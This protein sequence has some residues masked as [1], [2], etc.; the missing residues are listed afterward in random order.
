MLQSEWFWSS[1]DFTVF[2]SFLLLYEYISLIVVGFPHP[3]LE[4]YILFTMDLAAR[5][6]FWNP[7]DK[8]PLNSEV[9]DMY[10]IL[11]P[12]LKAAA[13]NVLYINI[14][15]YIYNTHDIDNIAQ[16][17]YDGPI[18]HTPCKTQNLGPFFHLKL[19]M[20]KSRFESTT[21]NGF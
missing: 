10:K 20:W 6:G 1:F 16:Y 21:S 19:V 14:Y 17:C 15:I 2:C 9:N 8:W 4:E 11:H 13:I 3:S 18:F 5:H 7:W 12:N